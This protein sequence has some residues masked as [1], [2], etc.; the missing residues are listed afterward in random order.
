MESN[1]T[2][3]NEVK[4]QVEKLKKKKQTKKQ[5]KTYENSNKRERT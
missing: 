1:N 4:K 3:I 5:D 2:W